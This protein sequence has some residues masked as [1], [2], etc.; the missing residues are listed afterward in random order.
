MGKIILRMCVYNVYAHTYVCAH[1]CVCISAG[2]TCPAHIWKSEHSFSLPTSSVYGFY[3]FM[4]Y[5]GKVSSADH[6]SA[7]QRRENLLGADHVSSEQRRG[8]LLGVDPDESN[9]RRSLHTSGCCWHR[10][11]A[12]LV[13][14]LVN[15]RMINI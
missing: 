10:K 9:A 13:Y 3:G 11:H 4:I 8:N 14:L 5:L 12:V 6:V 7:E 2:H 15:K 1:L